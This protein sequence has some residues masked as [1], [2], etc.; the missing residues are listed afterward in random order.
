[1]TRRTRNTKLLAFSLLAIAA[2]SRHGVGHAQG[3]TVIETTRAGQ[4]ASAVQD[5]RAPLT[6]I[7]IVFVPASFKAPGLATAPDEKLA[8]WN[9]PNLTKLMQERAPKVLAANGLTG[10]FIVLPMPEPGGKADLS[11][12]SPD[13]P[14]L[15]LAPTK[16]AKSSP[17]LF[18][19]TGYVEFDTALVNPTPQTPQ[20]NA[21]IQ[22]RGG[23]G[24]DP[25]WGVLKTNRVDAGWVDGQL[26]G[27]LSS[28]AR[29][30]VIQLGADK[31]VA[32]PP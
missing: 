31:V 19:W 6:E 5:G 10:Q 24:F 28:Y 14:A 7:D 27:L 20:S 12:L 25:V 17:R 32:P 2:L 30:G 21:R 3:T 23:L 4:A 9:V 18:V 8:D 26:M 16:F 29:Q 22:L 13:R 11:T 15:L 1:M